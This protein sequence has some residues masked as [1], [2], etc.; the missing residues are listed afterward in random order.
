MTEVEQK[1][2]L[3][4]ADCRAC[5]HVVGGVNFFGVRGTILARH[6]GLDIG[7]VNGA[8]HSLVEKGLVL[9]EDS[10][11]EYIYNLSIRGSKILKRLDRVE[12]G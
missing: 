11:R 12:V 3:A 2:L 6:A 8:A 4:L 1:V 9:V 5:S 7:M 10:P